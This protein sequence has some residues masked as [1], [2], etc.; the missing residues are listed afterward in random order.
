MYIIN[1]LTKIEKG[2]FERKEQIENA[3]CIY[4]INDATKLR[5]EDILKAD[6]G[7]YERLLP[8]VEKEM[9][10][11]IGKYKNVLSIGGGFPKFEDKILKAKK[12]VI[13]DM[14]TAL[15]VEMEKHFRNIFDSK[16]VLS[17]HRHHLNNPVWMDNGIKSSSWC[18]TFVHFLEHMESWQKVKAWINA[19]QSDIVI[20]MP[21]IEAA[22]DEHWFHWHDQHNVFFT[23]E[24]I[25]K[26][27]ESAGYT[28]QSLRYSDDMLIWFKR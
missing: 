24:A 4:E 12:A 7:H 3:N 18:T 6:K 13:L 8:V 22:K 10:E 25:V 16:I 26:V 27:G 1:Y 28:C 5:V 14:N 23:V 20:Y 19:Q 11:I 21:C 17:Y 9:P 15:Y 2:V